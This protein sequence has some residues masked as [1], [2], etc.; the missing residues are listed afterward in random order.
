MASRRPVPPGR[1][2]KLWLQRRLH[3]GRLAADL[4]D[5]RLR[6]LRV[7]QQRYARQVEQ[8]GVR[9][10][11]SWHRADHW[12]LRGA[13]AGGRRELRLAAPG[14][15]AQVTVEWTNLVGIRFPVS[16]TCE[17]PE[18]PAA[19]RGPGTAALVEAGEAYRAAVRA[20]AAYAAA[21]A[22]RAA[23]AAEIATTR[24]RLRAITDRWIPEL[25]AA[26]RDRVAQ[27]EEDERAEAA[28]LRRAVRGTVGH[29]SAGR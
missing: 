8:S 2:G 20:A 12:G 4:L 29:P 1:A 28:R 13:L 16:A 15:P 11:E 7:E 14:Q 22:A 10:R 25:E 21:D 19:D 5:R 3:T 9:W 26:L 6:I 18:P 17:P 23:I 27:L 24:R